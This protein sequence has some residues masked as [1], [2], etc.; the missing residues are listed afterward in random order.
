MVKLKDNQVNIKDWER[1]SEP[2]NVQFVFTAL[3]AQSCNLLCLSYMLLGIL[4]GVATTD[5]VIKMACRLV[6]DGHVTISGY[7][8]DT[9]MCAGSVRFTPE[10][11]ESVFKN[12]LP[13]HWH[14]APL[15]SFV[16]GD[17][18]MVPDGTLVLTRLWAN[19]DHSNTHFVVRKVESNRLKWVFNPTRD[20]KDESR[21]SPRYDLVCYYDE[22][23]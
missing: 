14:V 6:A 5:N 13:R 9:T 11:I 7:T 1:E 12:Y 15:A 21:W 19:D 22:D 16:V 23:H 3:G 18:Y 17:K 8:A 4:G 10:N 20:L 2:S